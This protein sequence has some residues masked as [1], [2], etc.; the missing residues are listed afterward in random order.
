MAAVTPTEQDDI[1]LQVHGL[2]IGDRYPV[3]V[4]GVL[5]VSPESFYAGSVYAAGALAERARDMIQAGATILDIGARST[6]PRSPKITVEE[7]TA[8]LATSLEALLAGCDVGDTLLSVDT[9]FRT[10]AEK[11]LALCRRAGKDRQLVLNDVSCLRADP[12][13][14]GWIAETGCPVILMA[15]HERPGDSLGV[16]ETL[17]D[18]ERGIDALRA[19]GVDT[20]TKL[21]VDP[22]IGRWTREKTAHFD[23]EIIRELEAFRSLHA[24]IL[25]GVS[26]KSFIGEILGQ[27]D[28][29][30]RLA[31]THA[32]TAIA[33]FRGAHIVRTHDVTPETM[34]IARVA[35]AIRAKE[36]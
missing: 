26:R 28:P 11:A 9:Q 19:A 17:R 25:V 16:L 18:L 10:V 5:N 15:A 23:C 12:T 32:A 34:D 27:P 8:R 31:G 29:A 35:S 14:A 13:L 36:H 24:P 21:I 4:M 7:E 30:M 3:R 2:D 20:A 1:S 22:A 6:A 33:V